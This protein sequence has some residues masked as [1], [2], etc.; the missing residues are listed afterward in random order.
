MIGRLSMNRMQ[1]LEDALQNITA[2]TKHE[3]GWRPGLVDVVVYNALISM[4]EDD[5]QEGYYKW[6]STPDVIMEKIMNSGHIFDLEYGMEDLYEALR[7][8]LTEKDFVTDV[9]DEEEKEEEE[10]NDN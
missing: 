6:N 7:D 4:H 8:Y 3:D 10:E 2:Y 9:D 1:L 5:E